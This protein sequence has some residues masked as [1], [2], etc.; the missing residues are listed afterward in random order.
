MN[1][2]ITD[3]EKINRLPW[4]AAADILNTAFFLLTFSGSIFL[5]FLDELGLDNSQIGFLLSLVPF[6]GIIAPF[7]APLVRRLGYKRVYI[8]FWT[9]RKFV[10]S[11]LLLTPII[12]SR[13]GPDRAFMWVA[14]VLLAFAICRAIA[15]TGGYPWKKEAVPDAMRGKFTAINNMLSTVAGIAVTGGASYVIGTG[16]GLNRFMILIAAGIVIGFISVWCYSRVPDASLISNSEHDTGHLKGMNQALHDRE[17]MF[18]LGALGLASIGG[19]AVI[20][21]I[22]LF[23]KEQVGLSESN[24][25]LLSIGTYAG[26]LLSSYLW[27]WMA[28]RYGSKP[29]MQSSLLIMLLLPLAWFLM[30]RHQEV[31]PTVAMAIAFVAGVATLAWQISWMRYL[32]VNAMPVENRSAYTAIYYAWFGLVS[33]LGPLL[34]GQLLDLTHDLQAQ[35]W[36]FTVDPYTPLFGLS[37]LL[38]GGGIIAVTQLHSAEATPFRR[39]AGMFVRGNPIRALESMIHYNLSG[40]E[41]TRVFTT[42]RMGDAKN[43]LSSNELIEALSDPSFNVRYEAI[44]S[45]GRM[46]PEPKLVDALLDILNQEHSELSFVVIGS[47]G[48]LGDPRAIEPLRRL[49]FSGYHMLEANSARSLAM[50]NDV[51]SA[52]TFL[53]K[54]RA[55]TNQVLRIAY[56]SALGKVRASEAIDDIFAFLRNTQAEVQRGEIGL[57]LARIAGDERYYMQHWRLLRASPNTATAQAV[58]ALNKLIKQGDLNLL[59][60]T[61]QTCGRNF[62]A[63]DSKQGVVLLRELICQIPTNQLEPTLAHILQECAGNLAE[64]GD[65]RIEFILLSLH[66]LNIALGQLNSNGPVTSS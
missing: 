23:M 32:F 59:S 34:A 31:S 61:T 38:L 36:L 1:S 16:S 50:L 56:I 15:E 25:V 60:Q 9:L 43:L 26:A 28:D 7:I 30:P 11:L 17:F 48:R 19:T 47:L 5:L 58:L 21:F 20:S 2:T 44:R 3:L 41:M 39:F 37:A 24:V 62:A 51:E 6:C 35:F 40:D 13:Y 10:I 14:G 49:L 57:A 12:I 46:P 55:E 63:G 4:L 45:I 54:F 33:G 53:E 42:E 22:P 66:T 64:F 52:P 8:T 18:F 27:G 65:H 29:I